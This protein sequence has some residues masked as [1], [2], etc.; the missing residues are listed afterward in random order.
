MAECGGDVG[1]VYCWWLVVDDGGSLLGCG[2]LW[3][4]EG[5]GADAL[6]LVNYTGNSSVP[7]YR[8]R[9]LDAVGGYNATLTNRGGDALGCE[10]YDLALRVAE[11]SGVAVATAYLVAYRKHRGTMTTETDRMWR[12]HQRVLAATRRRRPDLPDWVFRHSAD[13]LALYLAGVSWWTRAYGQ[14]VRWGIR[15][16][17]AATTWRA[18]PDIARAVS[19]G[20]GSTRIA[21]PAVV[22]RGD[23]FSLWDLPAPLIPYGR[24][25]ERPFQ[26]LQRP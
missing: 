3:R 11:V 13:Q 5:D 10:D 20:P 18:L 14:A 17:R 8:R 26:R 12:A 16:L 22:R 21:R 1:L 9:Y 15:G 19:R 2:P 6:V 24:L 4:M 25:Y 7:M 23:C